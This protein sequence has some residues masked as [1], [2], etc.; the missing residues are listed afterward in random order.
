MKEILITSSVLILVLL[1]LRWAFRSR[2]TRRAQYALWALVLVRL[3]VPLSLPGT[4]F[5]VLT[6]AQPVE[7]QLAHRA[8][9]VDDRVVFA[10]EPTEAETTPVQSPAQAVPDAPTGGMNSD[11]QTPD[12]DSYTYPVMEQQTLTLGDLLPYLWYAGMAVTGLWFLFCNLRFWQKLRK[13]STPYTVDGC[14]YLVYLVEEGLPLS[15]PLWAGPPGYLSYSGG[16]FLTGADAACDRPR[17][18]PRPPWR[19]PVVT[20]AVRVP[21]RLLVRPAGVDRGGGVQDRL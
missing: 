17:E 15:L 1:A 19:S 10:W 16:S 3:L 12:T 8:E 9:A 6:A 20:A 4:D 2:I 5:S 18:R 14:K 21:E 13:G 7:R 11:A